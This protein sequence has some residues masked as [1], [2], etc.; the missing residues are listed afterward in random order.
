MKG[1]RA[2][3][4]ASRSEQA[5]S[6]A[7]RGR[8]SWVAPLL[9]GLLC[10]VVYNANLRCINSG[11]TLAAR[12]LPFGI[13]RHGTVAL[14]PIGD[15]VAHGHPS[16]ATW[17][18]RPGPTT[19]E[20]LFEP[21]AY[22]IIRGHDGVLAS[23][24]PI[25]A[26]LLVAPLYLPAV[27]Y[28]HAHGWQPWQVDWIAAVMEKLS[29]SLL[30][31]I[32]VLLLYRLL[33]RDA[34]TGGAWSLALALAFAFGTN[35]W[36]I[37][38]QA[39]WQH[40]AGALLVA[41][42]LL[43]VTSSR[44]GPMRWAALGAV[45]VAMA[46]NRPPDVFLAGAMV[47]YAVFNV[48]RALVWVALGAVLPLALVLAYNLGVTGSL[49]GGY[50]T[51]DQRDFLRH[52]IPAGLAGLLLSPTR[53][54]LVFSPF[55]LF[56]PLGLVR[57]LRSP[58]RA[59]RL[60]TV[61]LLVGVLAHLAL[62]AMADWRQGHSWG[63]RWLTDVLPILIW[64]LAPAVLAL[65]P[66]ARALL[67]AT[68]VASIAIQAIGAFWYTGESDQA[69]YASA[70]WEPAA[71]RL[72][73][74]PFV[75]AL[76]DS[77]SGA[78][79]RGDLAC[80]ARGHVDLV[81]AAP[82]AEA[83]GV[84]APVLASGMRLQGWAL[85]CGRTPRHL[86][87]LVGGRVIAQTGQFSASRPD[88]VAAMGSRAASAW[89]VEANTAGL[90]PGEHVLQVAVRT[91]ERSDIRIVSES[92]VR[93]GSNA[94]SPDSTAAL[95]AAAERAA[96]LLREHQSAEGYW[97][98]AFTADT[99]YE[100]PGQEMNTYLTATLVD[101]VAPVAKE[102]GLE[103]ALNRARRHLTEQ[104]EADGLVRYHGLPDGPG[105]GVLGCPITP[106][107]DDTA[108]VWRIAPPP[109]GDARHRTMSRVRRVLDSYRD[110]RGF[111]RTWLAP[112]ERY[113]CIDPGRDPNPADLTIQMNLLL[114]FASR[115]PGHDPAAAR[116][117][118][119]ALA[120]NVADESLW[121]YYERA[122]LVPWLRTIDLQNVG[123]V[124]ELPEQRL[125]RVAGQ[126]RWK[127]VVRALVSRPRTATR[128]AQSSL[129][130]LDEL[131]RD[132]FAELRRSPP[133]LYHNDLTASVS[134]Y[135]WSEDFGYA[136]W[137]RLY[138]ELRAAGP[139]DNPSR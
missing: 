9:L 8:R 7:P 14:D 119:G 99:R 28:L 40:G 70:D 136:L 123:C 87:L 86:L 108:L 120:Q 138:E 75:A 65:R 74:A 126:E 22:W 69:L 112:R 103:A 67:G 34:G 92:R 12:Y 58:D 80:S 116:A 1:K 134:R 50:G 29:A 91:G 20:V 59:H 96:A 25:V 85:A 111:T 36:M 131:A 13:W 122:P 61:S 62:Y 139:A 63:P 101:F 79:P 57:R 84:P 56:V 95:A 109:A 82:A 77:R 97:L 39:L 124:V 31:T 113:Q 90:A 52:S 54:L 2:D 55:L 51:V 130:L 110:A 33:R 89:S 72:E 129:A 106:D 118:C 64:M 45:A 137:L 66:A 83:P 5:D 60:L 73:N 37:G 105:M 46:A 43:L 102:H 30:A 128:D 78:R 100:R 4:A 38:S 42:A 76:R 93:V 17:S 121:V 47:L 132:D 71:W 117:L 21:W 49:A 10:L 104:I 98:T 114:M 81:G 15:L 135:Y 27:A 24:Y 127:A 115:G 48:R 16:L 35:T 41:V 6:T 53:G 11:D 88:V 3:D 68:I 32:T 23:V 19:P 44:P 18:K 133:L 107:T 125:A 94:H 26:P